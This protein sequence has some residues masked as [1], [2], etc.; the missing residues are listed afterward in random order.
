MNRS[1]LLP[2]IVILYVPLAILYGLVTPIYEGPDEIGHVLYV[3]HVVEGRGIPVQ[4]REYAIDYG[5]GQEGSQAPLYYALNAALVRVFRLSLA[6]LERAPSINPFTTCGRPARYNVALYRHDPRWEEFPYRG[7]ARAVHVMRLFSALLGGVTVAAVY[8]TARL[9]FPH[10]VETAALAAVLVAFN[11][12]FAFMGGLVNNDN[13]VNALTALTVALA[14]YCSRHGFTWR[15]VGALGV[16]CGLALL[17]KA[18][19]LLA[20][21]FVEMVLLMAH[22]RQPKRLLGY[23]LLLWGTFLPVAGWWLV[24]NW[25]LYGDPTGLHRLLSI[26]G[27][28]RSWPAYLVLPELIGGFRSYWA[29]FACDLTFPPPVYWIFASVVGAGIWGLV[30]AWKT[31]PAVQKRTAWLLLAWLSLVFV[32]WVYWN[33]LDGSTSMGRLFF[34]A[35][36]A[37]CVLLACGLARLTPRPRWVLAGV[38]V[39]LW[40]LALVGALLV[41]RPAFA[42]PSRYPASA[43][44]APPQPLPQTAFGD[45]ITALGYEVSARSLEP[46]QA[47]EVALFLQTTQPITED[48]ALALQLVSPVPGEDATLVKFD[49]IPGGGNYPTYTWRPDEVIVDW[50]RLQVPERVERTRAWRVV[51]ILYRLSDG[52]RLP[53]TVAGQLGGRMLGL[54]L[55]RVGASER[56]EVPL[57]ARLESAPLFGEVIR[58]EGVQLHPEGD[59]LRVQAWWQAVA[60]PPDDYT[61]LVHLYDAEGMLLTAGDAPP[62]HGAFPTSMWEPGDRIADEYVL[63]LDEQGVLVGLGWYDSSTGDRLPVFDAGDRLSGDVWRIPLTP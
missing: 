8:A 59:R 31:V 23:S 44:P 26:N 45:E 54:G 50:Y 25:T 28:R 18:G 14:M 60:R 4:T 16:V 20:L 62:L 52:E 17:A 41:V 53:V 33:R 9:A 49:T 32:A 10:P 19:G 3:K 21:A 42:L 38:G 7:A 56:P 24:R 51:A 39:G 48:Y 57:E 2:V 22:W 63:P 58:L 30:R 35:N 37:G 1:R 29:T 34:Q 13:L 55:V 27:F 11:A 5:F 12:Q 43:P 40:A 47:L 15:R 6:D 46:D 36:A 61:T